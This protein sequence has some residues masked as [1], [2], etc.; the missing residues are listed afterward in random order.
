MCIRDS[1]QTDLHIQIKHSQQNIRQR[2]MDRTDQVSDGAKAEPS[3]PATPSDPYNPQPHLVAAVHDNN[4][5]ADQQRRQKDKE[6]QRKK[7]AKKREKQYR[8]GFYLTSIVMN[9]TLG[10]FQCGYFSSVFSPLIDNL[11]AILNLP[12]ELKSF[13]V[14]LISSL[15]PLGGTVGALLAGNL[16][17]KWGSRRALLLSDFVAALGTIVTCFPVLGLVLLGRFVQGVSYGLNLTLVA[18]YINEMVT[19]DTQGLFGSAIG[20]MISLGAV[21]GFVF[22]FGVPEPSDPDYLTSNWWRIMFAFPIVISFLRL[23]VFVLFVRYDT[24]MSHVQRGQLVRA[25]SVLSLIYKKE[26]ADREYASL[27][28]MSPTLPPGSAGEPMSPGLNL[29]DPTSAS[30]L[31]APEIASPTLSS[32]SGA[33]TMRFKDLFSYPY[34]KATILTSLLVFFQQFTGI[35]V[36]NFYAGEIFKGDPSNPNSPSTTTMLSVITSIGAV[37]ASLFSGTLIEKFGRKG[38]LLG[39]SVMMALNHLVFV[40]AVYAKQ[41]ELA[42]ICVITCQFELSLTI[43]AVM[44]IILPE[45]IPAKGVS[46]AVFLNL[47]ATL[48]TLQFFPIIKESSIGLGGSFLIFLITTT[49]F[50]FV[51]ACCVPETKG[52]TLPDILSILN[53]EDEMERKIGDIEKSEASTAHNKVSPAMSPYASNTPTVQMEQG[54]IR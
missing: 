47:V 28:L 36:I 9:V 42:A 20:I 45:L 8:S 40:T 25:E 16:K 19:R 34:A 51:S 33:T 31:K 43:G 27:S 24:P 2:S 30:K 3:T 18:I 32:M 10:S 26:F 17:M 29:E 52:K 12:S 49:M 39:G 23:L 7:A 11:S 37:I 13:Y 53:G 54:K 15:I 48:V 35:G 46:F 4:P 50:A 1:P 38:I 21:C 44:W 41:F 14:G 22:G 6:K 5:N